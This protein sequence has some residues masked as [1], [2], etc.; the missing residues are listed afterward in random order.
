MVRNLSESICIE[1]HGKYHAEKFLNGAG[2]DARQSTRREKIS[3]FPERDFDL[4]L[5]E[6]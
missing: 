4:Q 2:A 5:V 1:G 6:I 3:T